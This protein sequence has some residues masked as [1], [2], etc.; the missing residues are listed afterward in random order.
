MVGNLG[1]VISGRDGFGDCNRQTLARNHYLSAGD[2]PVVDQDPHVVL[3]PG[4]ELDNGAPAH[5]Q[6]VPDRHNRFAEDDGQFDLDVLD[7]RVSRV[8]GLSFLGALGDF[9]GRV[10]GDSGL[11]FVSH[12]TSQLN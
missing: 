4:L 10:F 11:T 1:R 6:Q 2:D 3:D 9:F 7:R 5:A 8:T 12:E